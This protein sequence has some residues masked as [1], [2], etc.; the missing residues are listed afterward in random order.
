LLAAVLDSS[1]PPTLTPSPGS[2]VCGRGREGGGRE[3]GEERKGVEG[4]GKGRGDG[5]DIGCRIE[6]HL[7]LI[8]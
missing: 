1:T 3:K 7:Q 6:D 8:N 5:L 4:E 2:E